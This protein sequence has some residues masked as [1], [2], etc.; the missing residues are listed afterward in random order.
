MASI[1]KCLKFNLKIIKSNYYNREC[2]INVKLRAVIKNNLFLY[3]MANQFCSSF[4]WV[5]I[6]TNIIR[7][8][9]NTI[10]NVIFIRIIY[11]CF[12]NN[13]P[14][15]TL[16]LY[17][18]IMAIVFIFFWIMNSWYD[19]YFVPFMKYKFY[20]GAY[21]K[22]LEKA[23]MISIK[24]YDDTK[25]YENFVWSMN[26]ADSRIYNAVLLLGNLFS[27]LIYAV[28]MIG[29]IFAIDWVVSVSIFVC[30]ALSLF[31]N[32]CRVKIGLK[33]ESHLNPLNCKNKYYDRVMYLLEYAKEIK[34]TPIDSLIQ[35]KFDDSINE[36]KK[37]TLFYAKR[38]ALINFLMRCSTSTLFDVV[39]VMFMAYKVMVT[40]TMTI[41]EFAVV[42]NMIWQIFFALNNL[43]NNFSVFYENGIYSNRFK[44]FIDLDICVDI[45]QQ[46]KVPT[47]FQ[48]LSLRDVSFSYGKKVILKHINLDIKAGEKIAIV[49]YNGAGKSTL[50]KLILRLYEPNSGSIFMDDKDIVNYDVTSYQDNFGVVF[51]DYQ[52]FA[53]SL[54]ENVAMGLN[55]NPQKVCE[56]L[57]KSGFEVTSIEMLNTSL[58][59]EFDEN[60][61]I[62]SG[63]QRQKVA[64]S[65]AFYKNC[66]IQIFDEPSSSL[67][68]MVEEEL[69]RSIVIENKDKTVI[70]ISHR[71]STV[72]LADRI[73]FLNNGVIEEIGDHDTLMKQ[74]GMYAEMFQVQAS[75][76]N[77]KG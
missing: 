49:G 33:K 45:N 2:E 24:Y 19:Q 38:I 15:K 18:S 31:L 20:E 74:N 43:I 70:F 7:G 29:L 71:L 8:I 34:T 58:T 37:W 13:L 9:V 51:Q 10:A 12:E 67:D 42:I 30:I 68:P 77:W 17:V 41:S 21:K 35:Q 14:F 44:Q 62:L 60:G 76:Y 56:A 26:E 40:K 63:G 72:R 54:S 22:I 65:R 57:K 46:E 50:V 73:V 6:L 28:S 61:L 4:L 75:K 39:L 16:L 36:V 23:R 53:T 3:K 11:N 69:N 32:I 47:S 66:C 25:F 1:A 52:I 59:K 48:T 5:T 55:A 64:V 27:T